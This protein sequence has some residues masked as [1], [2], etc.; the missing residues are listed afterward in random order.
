M[1][2]YFVYKG[3]TYVQVLRV[4]EG[5]P[6]VICDLRQIKLSLQLSSDKINRFWNLILPL[7]LSTTN[8]LKTQNELELKYSLK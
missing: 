7:G 5:T 4:I 2:F 6:H 3:H 1:N 8:L